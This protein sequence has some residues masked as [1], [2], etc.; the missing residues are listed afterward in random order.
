MTGN[1]TP[2]NNA[3]DLLLSIKDAAKRLNIGRTLMYELVNS[4]QVESVHI[5]K[6]HRVPVIALIRYAERLTA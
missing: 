5:G 4:G 3:D 2:L 1:V 6:L